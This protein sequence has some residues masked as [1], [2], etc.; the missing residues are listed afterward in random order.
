MSYSFQDTKN[1]QTKQNTDRE[2][3]VPRHKCIASSWPSYMKKANEKI[4]NF[5]AQFQYSIEVKYKLC[6]LLP[7]A[8]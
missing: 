2:R 7:L 3:G 6:S 1:L 5:N 4:T 8:T